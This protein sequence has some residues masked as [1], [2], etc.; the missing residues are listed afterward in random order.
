MTRILLVEDEPIARTMATEIF[1]HLQVFF[2]IAKDGEEALNR[3]QKEAYDLILCDL[4]LPD[5]TGFEIVRRTK[6]EE[7]PNQKTPFFAL[8]SHGDERYRERAIQS[9]MTGFLP[10]PLDEKRCQAVIESVQYL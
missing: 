8:T 3:L 6:S 4:G 7:N 2:E 1:D 9:G 5:I 10:K